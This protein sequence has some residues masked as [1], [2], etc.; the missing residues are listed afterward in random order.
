MNTAT[1]ARE[2]EGIWEYVIKIETGLYWNKA[3]DKWQIQQNKNNYFDY[4]TTSAGHLVI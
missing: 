4:V 1:L 2:R 3:K